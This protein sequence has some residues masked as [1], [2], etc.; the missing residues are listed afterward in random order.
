M[1]SDPRSIRNKKKGLSIGPRSASGRR[2]PASGGHFSTP[3]HE[4][5]DRDWSVQAV[6]LNAPLGGS[7]FKGRVATVQGAA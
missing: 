6:A 3:D 7:R 4:K 2:Y 1:L 5:D